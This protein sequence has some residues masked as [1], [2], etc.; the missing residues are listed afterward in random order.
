MTRVPATH[1]LTSRSE[2]SLDPAAVDS[3]KIGVQPDYEQARKKGGSTGT[4]RGDL[5]FPSPEGRTV[6]T[7]TSSQAPHWLSAALQAMTDKC[8]GGLL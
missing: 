1:N 4:F 5:E 6:W 3:L 8:V 7:E 2:G